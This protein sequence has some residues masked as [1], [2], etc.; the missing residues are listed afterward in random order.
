M[1]SVSYK[2]L[3]NGSPGDQII[4]TRGIR[5]GDPLSPYLFLLCAEGLSAS[6]VN[7]EREGLISGIKII[8][9][10]STITHL[11]FADDCY[12]FSRVKMNEINLIKECLQEFS[13]ASGQVINHDKSELVFNSNTPRQF[14]R[15]V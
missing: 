4:P 10:S 3:I 1:S 6:L 12:I 11:L 13:C 15:M 5:Q 14:R 2:I 9:K 7:R 8:I